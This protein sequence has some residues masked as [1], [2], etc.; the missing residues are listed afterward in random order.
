VA[1]EIPRPLQ[2]RQVAHILT[3]PARAEHWLEKLGPMDRD[4]PLLDLGCGSGSFLAAVGRAAGAERRLLGVDIAM[5]WLLVARKRLEEEGLAHVPLVCACAERLPLADDC[6]GGIVAGDVI[7]HVA[8][9][10]ATLAEAH[11]VLAPGG[12][13]VMATPN[14]FSLAPEPHVG[15]WGVG[16]LPRK[17]MRGYVRLFK[18]VDFRAIRTVGLGE[19][20]RLLRASPFGGGTVQAPALP[21]DDLAQFG[22]LKRALGRAYNRLVAGRAGQALA[23]RAGPLF[24]VVCTRA[25]GQA[26]S[27]TAS[28]A[29]R[30]PTRP[31]AT[32]R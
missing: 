26:P 16:F 8:D 31:Q 12:R 1:G 23:L 22:R 29:T 27:R 25:A 15:V 13:L 10:T 19:C 11:R 2:R 5:R 7:E 18:N 20:R 28:P 30:R 21:A 6:A 4:R 14:R 17:F 32:R 3:A 9:Q 24:H